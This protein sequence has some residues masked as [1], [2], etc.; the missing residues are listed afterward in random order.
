MRAA[1]RSRVAASIS[2]FGRSPPSSGCRPAADEC[3]GKVRLVNRRMAAPH[4]HASIAGQQ[5]D[6]LVGPADAPGNAGQP[7]G[8]AISRVGVEHQRRVEPHR[9]AIARPTPAALPCDPS[10]SFLDAA[11]RRP[12]AARHRGLP[13]QPGVP[14]AS[15]GARPR[16]PASSAPDRRCD[17]FAPAGFAAG[18]HACLPN[19]PLLSRVGVGS[20]ADLRSRLRPPAVAIARFRGSRGRA[21]AA[22]A[23]VPITAFV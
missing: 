7:H 10:R 20:R 11:M 5:T 22:R 15:A 9:P 14:A 12:A 2:S 8:Q 18:R 6:R 19:E 13:R 16:K 4:R 23:P 3:Q 17:R 1:T 21:A